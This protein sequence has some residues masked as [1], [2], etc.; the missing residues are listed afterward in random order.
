MDDVGVLDGET[1]RHAPRRRHR[2]APHVAAAEAEPL[3][4][5]PH[6]HDGRERGDPGAERVA[7]EHEP[8][9]RRPGLR[10]HPPDRGALPVEQPHGGAEEPAVRVPAREW[11]GP[12]GVEEHAVVLEP[13]ES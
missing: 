9:P 1:E 7:D 4:P 11:L 8:A 13:R 2:V 10:H 6:R 5:A 12:A 3:Q